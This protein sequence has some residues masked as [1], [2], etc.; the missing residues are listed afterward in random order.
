M[1]EN[2]PEQL[3]YS[4]NFEE[5]VSIIVGENGCGKSTLLQ[6]LANHYTV[7]SKDVIGIANSI[8]DKFE[9]RSHN[10]HALRGRRGRRQTIETVRNAIINISKD[11][12]QGLRNAS[13]AL[14]YVGFDPIIGFQVKQFHPKFEEIILN[15]D[16]LNSETKEILIANLSKLRYEG[17][18]N[19]IIW[20][21]MR[22]FSFKDINRIS[23]S[24]LFSYESLL[25]KLNVINGLEFFLSKNN[26][27]IPLLHASSGELSLIT[28]IIFLATIIKER[29]TI[30]LIDEPENSLH[31]KWQKEYVKTILDIFY[32]YQPKIIIATHS[33]MIVN[34]AEMNVNNVLIYKAENFNFYLQQ[35]EPKNIEEI[36]YT[37]F[38]IT[39]P[40]N[41]FL[42]NLL[43][44]HLNALASKEIDIF[45]FRQN[46][47]DIERSIYDDRQANLISKV[48]EIALDIQRN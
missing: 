46:I 13:R 39:T 25:K 10:F 15:V 29:K 40:E 44:M 33:P 17:Q 22:G 7:R 5:D 11:N 38:E 34:G 6:Y 18:Y 8:H 24:N 43:V 37:F 16:Y 12:E 31:P 30:I 9:N 28:S 47:G 48:Y 23:L 42:S 32:Y 19:K 26:R 20:F 21:E 45:T 2:I 36:F 35:R 4:D 14:E 27:E 3:L 1:L 41:R